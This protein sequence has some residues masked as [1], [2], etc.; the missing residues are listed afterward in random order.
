MTIKK[1]QRLTLF[2]LSLVYGIS[3]AQ[4]PVHEEPLHRPVLE[5]DFGR[6]LDVKAQAGDTSLMHVHANNYVYVAL[7]GGKLWLEEAATSRVVNMPDGFI[8]GYFE[9]PNEPLVHRFANISDKEV[10]LIAVENLAKPN[11]I[12]PKSDRSV[13]NEV[14]NNSSFKVSKIT[15]APKDSL[16]QSV[17][18]P[19]VIVNVSA[20]SI[21]VIE[22]RNLV[23][24]KGW[25]WLN[26]GAEYHFSNRGTDYAILV[27][28]RLK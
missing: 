13:E 23:E 11:T 26:Q 6:V 4:I 28:V 1:L 19:A 14:I 9:N 18:G 25:K 3:T 17:N 22:D 5:N 15:I 2:F 16:T 12:K 8:G 7:H 21:R 10:R 27:L 20:A 24:L